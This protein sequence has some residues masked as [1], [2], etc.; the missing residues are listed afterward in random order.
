MAFFPTLVDILPY[1]TASA[2]LT[3][4]RR[5]PPSEFR[6]TLAT[7]FPA[8]LA[9]LTAMESA[10]ASPGSI[11]P[12]ITMVTRPSLPA[13]L[14]MSAASAPSGDRTTVASPNRPAQVLP[15]MIPPLHQF[16]AIQPGTQGSIVPAKGKRIQLMVETHCKHCHD[17]DSRESL[18]LVLASEGP[19]IGF[20]AFLSLPSLRSYF[21]LRGAGKSPWLDQCDDRA[22]RHEMRSETCVFGLL[23]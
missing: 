16:S 15:N 1:R 2:S 14:L 8:L 11:S 6:R 12:A 9:C 21:L 5:F 3:P 19:I 17:L 4:S 22:T 10:S 23:Q 7:N 20:L 13:V 18:R